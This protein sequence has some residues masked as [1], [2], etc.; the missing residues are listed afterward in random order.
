MNKT[1][2]VIFVLAVIIAVAAA[3]YYFAN[4]NNQRNN[5]Q[6]GI[7]PQPKTIMPMENQ[8]QNPPQQNPEAIPPSAP[9]NQNKNA[10]VAIQNF[11][12]NPTSLTVSVGTIIT[13]INNDSVPHQI[14]SNTFNSAPLS[15][16]QSFSYTFASPG[17]YDYSCAIH[18]ST[19]SQIIVQ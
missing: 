5:Y 16:G 2:W 4:N 7:L 12:F 1:I 19:H 3:V 17:T 13:W 14:K 10:Q 9:A 11:A 8:N 6:S 15:Q 18:S